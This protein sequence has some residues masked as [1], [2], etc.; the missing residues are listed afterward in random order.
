M[1]TLMTTAD[2]KLWGTLRLSGFLRQRYRT[3]KVE[4]MG[5]VSY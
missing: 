5:L 1:V 3:T 4:G 2:Q